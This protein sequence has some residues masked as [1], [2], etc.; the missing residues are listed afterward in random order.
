MI[1]LKAPAGGK[2]VSGFFSQVRQELRQVTW[3]NRRDTLRMT[4]IVIAI[5]LAIGLYL[6]GLD[7]LLTLLMGLI[8]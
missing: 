8:I 6:G 4:T 3:P 2:F 1:D 7:Y 5:T